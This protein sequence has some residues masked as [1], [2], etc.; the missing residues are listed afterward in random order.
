MSDTKQTFD[1]V[2][3]SMMDVRAFDLGL[4]PSEYVRLYTK[5]KESKINA[6]NKQRESKRSIQSQS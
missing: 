5:L 3:R 1:Y 6:K 4:P 2:E